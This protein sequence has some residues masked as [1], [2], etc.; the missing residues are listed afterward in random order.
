MTL[1]WKD[2]LE[3][4]LNNARVWWPSIIE[5]I[6][7]RSIQRPVQKEL[8]K[9]DLPEWPAT[10][11]VWATLPTSTP[12]LEALQFDLEDTTPTPKMDL[13]DTWF[14][15]IPE[16]QAAEVDMTTWKVTF[17]DND[18]EDFN[19]LLEN[20]FTQEEA[21]ETLIKIRQEDAWFVETKEEKPWFLQRTW[22]AIKIESKFDID[23]TAIRRTIKEEGELAWLWESFKQSG[24]QLLN[25]L[26]FVGNVP[27]DTLEFVWGLIDA[28]S[29]PIE[30]AKSMETLAWGLV[31]AWL[32][33]AFGKDVY[34]S[35]E[36]RAAVQWTKK[37]LEEKFWTVDKALET[38]TQ[39][40]VDTLTAFMG[41]TSLSKNF[42]K[43]PT[44]LAKINQF[45]QIINPI[46]ILKT[47]GKL[48]Q[49]WLEKIAKVPLDIWKT[50]TA[51]TSWLNPD[52]LTQ[53]FK[54]PDI[55][56]WAIT[57]EWVAQKVVKAIDKRVEEVWELGKAY[58]KFRSWKV[59]AKADDLQWV[60]DIINKVDIKELSK[61]EWNMLDDAI[62]YVDR[63][64]NNIT[65]SNLMSLR[66]QIDSIKYD[67]TW[68][69]RKL[70][71]N[72]N[73]ILTNI[74]NAV[75]RLAWQ[76]LKWLKE[77]DKKFAPEIKEL[78][79]VKDLMFDRT[80]NLK[81]NY[82]QTV[83]NLLWKGKEVKLE[84][85]RKLIPEIE[86][87]IRAV[88]ALEDVE[89]AKWNKV[90]TYFQTATLWG[91]LWWAAFLADPVL[92]VATLMVTSPTFI[93]NAVR[94]AGYTSQKIGQITNKIKKWIKL[95]EQESKIVWN[96]IKE[97]AIETWAR[98]TEKIADTVWARAKFIDDTGKGLDDLWDLSLTTRWRTKDLAEWY[99]SLIK[100]EARLLDDLELQRATENRNAIK[101][102]ED[103]LDANESAQII[104]VKQFSKETWLTWPNAF[105]VLEEFNLDKINAD[106]LLKE[107][108]WFGI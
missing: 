78:R 43:D 6:T 31:E 98:A 69:L 106:K 9:V 21:K 47:E 105:T 63:Y 62:G 3:Q 74:R 108:K 66:K 85:V 12:S 45:E 39:N 71:P 50:L 34:T 99:K 11:W 96:A 84:R 59:V 95:T 80:W 58:N 91:G 101:Q 2:K 72:G 26:R 89:F 16:A 17:D 7:Q 56:K 82:I 24:K 32:N 94:L 48:A 76:K 100:E 93:S 19:T 70:T 4:D 20:W 61:S 83:S 73:R 68:N 103:A 46:N 42:I 38:I 75:D 40:P 28:F 90:G 81:D 97:Q 13:P 22:K 52:T 44:K 8:P 79:K 30:T 23:P 36:K 86:D 107:I 102:I 92:A 87:E 104:Q 49:L 57:K 41:W 55:V 10:T 25:A 18:I 33:K 29:S 88:K 35:E 37:V 65:D 67:E 51:K 5:Q 14:S 1:L 77:L 54:N 27:W 15:F 64:T 53:L 60:R